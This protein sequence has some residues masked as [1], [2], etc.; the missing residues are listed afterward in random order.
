M[1][2]VYDPLS[3][4]FGGSNLGWA[5]CLANLA[6]APNVA[7]AQ[8][9]SVAASSV[10]SAGW[11]AGC[12]KAGSPSGL[13]TFEEQWM[14][15]RGGMMVG[16]SRTVRDGAARGYELAIIRVGDEGRLVYHA[17][18]SGQPPA[19][20][21]ARLV[22]EGRLEFVNTEHDFPQKII[23][24]QPASDVIHAAVFG[25]ATDTEPA[26]MIRYRRVKCGGA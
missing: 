21:P 2:G 23:Y 5:L 16:M 1:V 12:W 7:M 22:E 20:F 25:R 3:R 14:V 6:L 11:L 4:G 18:P 24:S 15:P 17:E 19:D 9:D 26:F 10:E 8:A 13:T